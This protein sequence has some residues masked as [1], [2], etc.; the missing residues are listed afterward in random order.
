M[1]DLHYNLDGKQSPGIVGASKQYLFSKKFLQDNGG[2]KK[3]CLDESKGLLDIKSSTDLK[4]SSD[5]SFERSRTSFYFALN[6][7][8][9]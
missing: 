9:I 3:F 4:N 5:F 2:I 8:E 6:F 7:S 1:N